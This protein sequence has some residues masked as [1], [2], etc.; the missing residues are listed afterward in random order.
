MADV[1]ELDV[2]KIRKY[3]ASR[4]PS[5]FHDQIRVEATIRGRSVTIVECRPPWR[6]DLGPEWSRHGVAQMRY[7]V[8]T[9]LWTL[10]WADRNS[11]WHVFDPIDP[12]KVGEILD[13]IELDRTCI[14]WG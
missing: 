2:A 6:E 5:E 8:D 13:E 14:F 7:D 9:N 10:Y 4:V 1:P 12:A 11:R 3:C